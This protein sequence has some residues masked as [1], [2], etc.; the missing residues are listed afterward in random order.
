MKS[1]TARNDAY[2]H[3]TWSENGCMVNIGIFEYPPLSN[4]SEERVSLNPL[5]FFHIFSLTNG[6]L[7][8]PKKDKST[9]FRSTDFGKPSHATSATFRS[10]GGELPVGAVAAMIRLVYLAKTR[11]R[12][13][14]PVRDRPSTQ[15]R[16]DSTKICWFSFMPFTSSINPTSRPFHPLN[17]RS[18]MSTLDE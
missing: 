11:P 10:T 17:H 15:W 4:G 12:N 13:I 5:V 14:Y 7:E 16:V 18:L 9:T 3:K 1:R 6:H 2:I 8:T